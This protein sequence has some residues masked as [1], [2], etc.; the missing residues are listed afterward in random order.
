MVKLVG[1]QDDDT[2]GDFVDAGEVE[3]IF[4]NVS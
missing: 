2:A 4:T 1:A 3:I